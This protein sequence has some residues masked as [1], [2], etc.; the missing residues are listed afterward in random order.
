MSIRDNLGGGSVL[1]SI[2]EIAA[3]TEPGKHAGALAVKELNESLNAKAVLLAT[4]TSTNTSNVQTLTDNIN[5]YRFMLFLRANTSGTS[6][7]SSLYPVDVFKSLTKVVAE[8]YSPSAN[9]NRG[10]H[11]FYQTDTTIK[12]YVTQD[13]EIG[14]IYGIK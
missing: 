1:D 7:I 12:C 4:I 9:S 10:L 13:T 2:E 8:Y 6:N 14:Y 5:N 11:V 3:N